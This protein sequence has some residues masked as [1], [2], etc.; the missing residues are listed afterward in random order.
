MWGICPKKFLGR[1]VNVKHDA[2][3]VMGKVGGKQKTQRWGIL[4]YC[5]KILH[6]SFVTIQCSKTDI[7][8]FVLFA[9]AI[10][11]VILWS[12]DHKITTDNK[13][14]KLW[15]NAA[16]YYMAYL[17][18]PKW[19]CIVACK[20]TKDKHI[21]VNVPLK[22]LSPVAFSAQNALNIVWWPGSAPTRCGSLERFPRPL[23][24]FARAYF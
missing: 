15:Q 21:L 10:A 16:W 20:Q 5:Y 11:I 22:L 12:R 3:C 18:L 1:P 19:C 17:C 9:I 4:I 13:L 14:Y 24:G 2:R 7:Q 23:A 6:N 8:R